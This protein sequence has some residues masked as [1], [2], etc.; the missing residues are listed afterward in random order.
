MFWVVFLSFMGGVV[1]SAIWWSNHTSKLKNAFKELLH[2]W[3]PAKQL[4]QR[5]LAS[6]KGLIDE[7]SDLVRDAQGLPRVPTVE[8]LMRPETIKLMRVA[9]L[10][11]LDRLENEQ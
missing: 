4:N 8:E 6:N 1:F 7:F 9:T 11:E 5:L 3:E 2:K 10:A